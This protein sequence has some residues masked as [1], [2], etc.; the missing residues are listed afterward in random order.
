[1]IGHTMFLNVETKISRVDSRIPLL[2]ILLQTCLLDGQETLLQVLIQT[3]GH[4]DKSQAL[5]GPQM[6]LLS[7]MPWRLISQAHM[8]QI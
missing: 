8:G 1:M 7:P 3:S 4:M 5:P 6:K 2:A